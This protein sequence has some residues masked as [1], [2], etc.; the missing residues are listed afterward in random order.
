V[1]YD[2]LE[3]AANL[4]S[5]IRSV[6]RVYDL[7]SGMKSFQIKVIPEFET[8]KSYLYYMLMQFI[9]NNDKLI[10]CT[11]CNEYIVEPTARELANYNNSGVITHAKVCRDIKNLKKDNKRNKVKYWNKKTSK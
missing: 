1:G 11:I 5:N 2:F 6:P 3:E 10:R 4:I 8:L 9:E 7:E